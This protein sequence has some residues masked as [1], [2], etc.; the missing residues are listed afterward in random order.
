MGTR[1][2]DNQ[3]RTHVLE[4]GGESLGFFQVAHEENNKVTAMRGCGLNDESPR[5]LTIRVTSSQHISSLELEV[6]VRGATA[7][8]Q[9]RGFPTQ[10]STHWHTHGV[11]HAHRDWHTHTNTHTPYTQLRGGG[12]T[13]GA[14]ATTP[15]TVHAAVPMPMFGGVGRIFRGAPT[16]TSAHRTTPYTNGV[17]TTTD[18]AFNTWFQKNGRRQTAWVRAPF[19]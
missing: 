17:W 8:S 2:S 12:G 15:R 5:A 10:H 19:A 13:G 3:P 11:S 9:N 14:R 6:R 4:P 7:V 18:P 1:V 16:V